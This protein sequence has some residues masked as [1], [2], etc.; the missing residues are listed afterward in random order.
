MDHLKRIISLA[1]RYFCIHSEMYQIEKV[2]IH[3]IIAFSGWSILNG[4]VLIIL[5]TS[6]NTFINE[7]IKCLTIAIAQVLCCIELAIK[8]RTIQVLN[9]NFVRETNRI[10]VKVARW[11]EKNE[12]RVISLEI[13]YWFWV[14]W[15]LNNWWSLPVSKFRCI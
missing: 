8:L 12:K 7:A 6:I 9:F 10:V 13:V 1:T 15:A 14:R 3:K 2:F 11:R 5:Q 4:S